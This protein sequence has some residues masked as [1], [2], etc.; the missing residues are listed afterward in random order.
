MFQSLPIPERLNLSLPILSL[1][2]AACGSSTIEGS[3]GPGA[4]EQGPEGANSGSPAT[5]SGTP[6]AG[7]GTPGSEGRDGDLP[8]APGDGPGR[9]GGGGRRDSLGPFRSSSVAAHHPSVFSAPLAGV[10]LDRSTTAVL[11]VGRSTR[12]YAIF[13]SRRGGV[14]TV[15]DGPELLAPSDLDRRGGELIVADRA[16]DDGGGALV[17]ISISSGQVEEVFA[18][19][20][21]PASVTVD[22]IGAIYLSGTDPLTREPG[23]FRVSEAGGQVETLFAG[24]P[25]V[26]PSGIALMADGRVLVAD[27]SL[28]G[29]SRG[30][31]FAIQDGRAELLASG[32]AAGFPAGIALTTD[33]STLVVSGLGDDGRDRLFVFDLASG[34]RTAVEAEF[35]AAQSS[36]GGLHRAPDGN[37]FIWSSGS[38]NGGTVYRFEG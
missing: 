15:Y 3:A 4:G 11:A 28:A 12:S 10:A 34:E 13:S 25:L 2:L 5:G 37:T 29:S 16:A 36:S 14:S 23:V 32:F 9:G 31:V 24:R 38:F 22:A 33:D 35:T 30:G 21:R 1:V 7:S 18:R 6:G 19:G 20:Y 8:L 27:T 17:S 26:D